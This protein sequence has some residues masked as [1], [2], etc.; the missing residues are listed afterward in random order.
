MTTATPAVRPGAPSPTGTGQV[1]RVE[2]E[3]PL[4]LWPLTLMISAYPVW[5]LLG[6]S[7]FMWVILAAPMA[8]SLVRR[9]NLVAPKGI[10]F[11]IVFL[12]AVAGSSFS[13]DT[14]GRMSGF[15]LR[16]GYYVAATVF[17]L[18]LLNGGLS[19]SVPRIVRSFTVL[20]M[21]SIAGGYM[22][23]VLG[24][25]SFRSPMY[26][27]M[28]AALLGNELI[29]TLVTPGFADL[30]DIIGFPVPRPK[31]PFSY[32][33][34][35]G[36]MTALTTPFAF[37]AL[38]DS[39][40][41]LSPRLVRWVLVASLVP[42][43][44]SLNRGLWLSL[45]VGIAYAAVRFGVGGQTKL[46]ARLMAVSV[47][48]AVAL[49]LSPLGNLVESRVDNGH[50][51]EDRI[52]L[53]VSAIDGAVERPV[54]GWGA[55]RPNVRNLPSVG[56]HGQIWL[57]TFSHGFLGIFGFVGAIV[58][59]FVRTRRQ[60]KAVGLWAHS[61]ILVAMVQMPVYLLIPHSLF[62]IMAAVAVAVRCQ[63]AND[64]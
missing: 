44:I 5:F 23:L 15:V 40:V 18:Y 29:N 35:W 11:W 25:F 56:T 7:G 34:S 63:Q 8:A 36:S 10:G 16:F 43:V 49:A 14:A 57:V 37:M 61:V 22:A 2:A 6:L 62:A 38:S 45:G 20:W 52:G 59:Y 53:A 12:I 48:V 39:R 60:T 9:R 24:D 17:L 28:P 26:Y 42:V 41:G 31:A 51:N 27:L 30:Q 64:Q 33:N 3:A 46:F 47:F 4:P 58:S 19:V 21:F 13:I 55:P 50:S 54:F 32:T 1:Y